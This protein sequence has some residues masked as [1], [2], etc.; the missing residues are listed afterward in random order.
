MKKI[1][2]S[3]LSFLIVLLCSFAVLD[4]E[5]KKNLLQV[6]ES[7]SFSFNSKESKHVLLSMKQGAYDGSGFHLDIDS[8]INIH[9]SHITQSTGPKQD[10]FTVVGCTGALTRYA[11]HVSFRFEKNRKQY[12][13]IDLNNAKLM[14]TF[15]SII[16]VKLIS[17]DLKGNPAAYYCSGKASYTSYS[18][19]SNPNGDE[20]KRDIKPA[21]I[22][23]MSVPENIKRDDL[24]KEV[25]AANTLAQFSTIEIIT[26][27]N[28]IVRLPSGSYIL[29]E[30]NTFEIK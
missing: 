6:G 9:V 1:K 16:E 30:G 25:H 5:L 23:L 22:H 21:S 2:F 20:A 13:L 17:S 15:D 18:K 19:S 8:N 24:F 14:D 27:N 12:F 3:I 11:S 29:C 28:R 7:I 4:K 26:S 10:E